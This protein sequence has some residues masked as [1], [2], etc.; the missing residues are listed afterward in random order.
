[1]NHPGCP[2]C[3]QMKASE[4]PYTL[5]VNAR[6]APQGYRLAT[7]VEE[8]G[9]HFAKLCIDDRDFDGGLCTVWVVRLTCPS[10]DDNGEVPT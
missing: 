7:S 8:P 4:R 2:V 1:M 10:C 9:A 6:L 5:R 3:I